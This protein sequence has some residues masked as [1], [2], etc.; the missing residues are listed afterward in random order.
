MGFF[1]SNL[2]QCWPIWIN[3]YGFGAVA[4]HCV[5]TNL[6]IL[7]QQYTDVLTDILILSLP[8][9]NIAT[10]QLPLPQKFAVGAMFGLGALTVC[11]GVAKVVVF[12]WIVAQT[13]SGSVDVS[14]VLTPSV[15]WPLI[16]SAIGI[17]GACLPLLR[18][19][20]VGRE[21][22]KG[23]GF[24]RG[25]RSRDVVAVRE[26][27]PVGSDFITTPETFAEDCCEVDVH[28]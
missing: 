23:C 2:F 4:S 5:N 18:P 17:V 1:F 6:M 9:P 12:N 8:I 28:G 11:S 15:Y 7:F 19:L 14:Y 25:L 22:G 24:V 3:W 20:V 27:K 10:L 16:E 26:E 21:E 13:Q